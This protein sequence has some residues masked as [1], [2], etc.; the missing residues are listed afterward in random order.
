MVEWIWVPFA[1]IGGMVL[2]ILILELIDIFGKDGDDR[3]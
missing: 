2:M 1:V 3:W